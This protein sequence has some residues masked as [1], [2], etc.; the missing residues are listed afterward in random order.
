[1][2]FS[3]NFYL[4]QAGSL[5][6]ICHHSI[7]NQVAQDIVAGLPTDFRTNSRRINVICGVHHPMTL[8][9]IVP[10]PKLAIQTEQFFDANGDPLWSFKNK[11]YTELVRVSAEKA[12]IVLDLSLCNEPLYDDLKIPSENRKKVFFG[13]HIFPT[14]PVPFNAGHSSHYVFYGDGGGDRRPSIIQAPHDFDLKVVPNGVYGD[15]LS[16]I[17]SA[18]RGVV[19]IHYHTGIYSESPRLLSAY[20][21]G[22]CVLSEEL[23]TPFE[24]NVHYSLLGRSEPENPERI[25]DNFSQLVTQ[26]F[27]FAK[28]IEEIGL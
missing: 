9:W 17:I 1:M 10:G 22:K 21:H 8:E 19:N 15:R 25:F 7:L 20:L 28:L 23:S 2:R 14:E 3:K 6:L 24:K 12:D 26:R 5:R 18:A 4:S 16:K 11:A 27:S 13:P